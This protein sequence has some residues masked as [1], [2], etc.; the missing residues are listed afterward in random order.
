VHNPSSRP[1]RVSVTALVSQLLGV[2]GLQSVTVPAGRRMSFRLGDH[3][4]RP[5]LP[6]LLE[7]SVPVVV[8]RAVYRS[9][10]T[11]LSGVVA[12]PLR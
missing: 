11:G 5:E 12:V 4:Q 7:S 6:L 10:A 1:A 9:G 3:I 8:E 2:E